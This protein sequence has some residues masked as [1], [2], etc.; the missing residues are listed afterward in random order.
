MINRV[1]D[2]LD[3]LQIENAIKP[4]MIQTIRTHPDMEFQRMNR[5][6]LSYNYRDKLGVHILQ[7]KIGPKEYE[8]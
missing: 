2:S 5:T 8:K 1:K 6:T 4:M 7:F 3:P